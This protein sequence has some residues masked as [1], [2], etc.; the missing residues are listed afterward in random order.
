MSNPGQALLALGLLAAIAGCSPPAT[1]RAAPRTAEAECP[2]ATS[3][4]EAPAPKPPVSPPQ[5]K[6]R[7]I[8]ELLLFYSS[9]YPAGNWKPDGLTFEDVWFR[10]EDGTRLHGWYCPCKKVRAVVLYAHGNAGNL[11]H[12]AARMKQL[13]T[14]L[15]VAA[16]IFDYRGYGRSE[17]RPTVEGIL[18]D[19]RAARKHLASRAGVPQ[20]QLVLMGR[21][22][23][24]AVVV[25]LAAEERARG[26]VVESTFSSLR[27]AAAYHY[28]RLAWL[29]P[30]GKLDSV[31]QIGRYKGPLL[32]SHGDSDRTI[33]YTQGLKLFD[34]AQEPKTFIRIPGADHND[35]PSAEYDRALDHFIQGLPGE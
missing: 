14:E 2:R 5:P 7:T 18:Q 10:A 15:R 21:S 1:D 20:T 35:P 31:S 12:R 13:Q 29:V 24:G 34:A 4:V 33:P 27:D 28:P 30:A 3:T 26:L 16:L 8:D 11:S 19:A 6:A 25:Q 9:K 22:L 17:G 23:G 32:L